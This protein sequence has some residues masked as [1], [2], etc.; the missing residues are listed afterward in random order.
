N[1][2]FM[3]ELAAAAGVDPFEF[4]IKYIDPA[5]KRGLE[6]LDRLGKLAKWEKHVSP[7]KGAGGSIVK[8][9]GM[10]YVKYELTRTYVG[11]VADI[12]VNRDNG[13][14]K[15]TNFYVAHDCGQI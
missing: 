2:C 12:E 13:E 3:D 1:E 6:L 9:R 8:G 15:V 5:D 14:I 7:Q 11:A 4:R 10:S